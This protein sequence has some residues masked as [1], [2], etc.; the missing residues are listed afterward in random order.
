FEENRGQL[1]DPYGK[2]LPEVKYY[3][4][5]HGI[6]LYCQNDRLS[7]VFTRVNHSQ[8][9]KQKEKEWEK[10]LPDN[11]DGY[12]DREPDST[13]VDAAR[14]EMQFVG[15]NPN[16]Q[17]TTEEKIDFY[18]NYYLAHTPEAGITHVGNYHKIIY[19][20]LYPNIDMIL[21]SR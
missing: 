2:L 4:H 9:K 3:G 15:A 21:Y 18:T 19:K 8:K 7:F 5:D 11:P 6:N 14:M 13:T 1:A 20:N 17:I 16:P 12:R 10:N